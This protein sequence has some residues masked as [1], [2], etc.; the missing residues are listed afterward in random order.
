MKNGIIK[1][2]F[3]DLIQLQDATAN[4]LYQIIV[5]K[6]VENRIPYKDNLIGF[7]SDGANVMMEAHHSVMSLLKN[8]VPSLFI[9]KCICHLCA[10]YACQKLPRFV[11][12]V[13]LDIYNYFS[14]SPKRAG[15]FVESFKKHRSMHVCN[16]VTKVTKMS[17]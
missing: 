11:E 1:D 14:S 2:K 7:A 10:S 6:F 16:H 8:D 13:T 5:D 15:E 3:F 4:S 12:D 9:M 17:T